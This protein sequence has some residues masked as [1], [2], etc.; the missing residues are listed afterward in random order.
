MTVVRPD[1]GV[2]DGA[3]RQGRQGLAFGLLATLIWGGFLVVSRYGIGA[4]LHATDLAFLR[5]LTAGLILLPWLLGHSPHRLAG[6]GW[7]KG[8]C[9]ALLAGPLFIV[10]SASGYRYAPLAHAAVI[11]LGM[12]TLVS[13]LLAAVM[14]GERPGARRLIGL[15]VVVAGLAVTAG[16]GLLRGSSTAWIGDLLFALAGSMWALFSVLQRRWGIAPLAATA[17]VSVLSAA[18]YTPLYLAGNGLRIFS[19]APPT[20]LVVQIVA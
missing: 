6:V 20:V 19:V 3:R 16:P 12:L 7:G 18:V 5:Y 1:A 13:I 8:M 14:V 15:G 4:G 11:Q 17:V 9:L 10:V 2:R